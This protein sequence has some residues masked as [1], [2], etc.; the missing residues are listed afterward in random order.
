MN[1]QEIQKSIE[2]LRVVINNATDEIRQ[3]QKICPHNITEKCEQT[4]NYNFEYGSYIAYNHTCLVCGKF[5][6]SGV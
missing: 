3:I 5:W 1:D 6:T 2:R 4:G